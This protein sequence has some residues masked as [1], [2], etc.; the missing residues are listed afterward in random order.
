MAKMVQELINRVFPF[1]FLSVE[2]QGVL[3]AELEPLRFDDGTAIIRQ[4]DVADGGVYIIGAGS[5]RVEDPARGIVVGRIEAGHYFGEWEAL[6]DVRRVYSIVAEAG[7]TCYRFSFETFLHLIEQSRSFAQS[8][9]TILRDK[10]GIFQAFERFLAEIRRDVGQGF[11]NI[12]KLLPLYRALEPALHSGAKS[13]DT[14]DFPALAYAI[15]R[16]PANVSRT[17]AYLLTYELP[18]TF[19][20]PSLHFERVDTD[21]RRR[22]VWSVLPGKN[23]ILLRNGLSDLLDFTTCLC[24]YANEAKKL[25][26]RLQ[27]ADS[28]ERLHELFGSAPAAIEPALCDIGFSDGEAADLVRLWGAEAPRRLYEITCHREM[29]SIAVRHPLNNYNTRRA[30]QWTTHVSSTVREL[31]DLSPGQMHEDYPVHIVSSNTHSV[32]NVLSPWV[33]RRRAEVVAWAESVGHPLAAEEFALDDDRLYALLRDFSE[34]DPEH[35]SRR[36]KEDASAGIVTMAKTASTGIAVQLVDLSRLPAGVGD[37]ALEVTEHEGLL[38]NI[39][40][41]FGEQAQHILHHLLLLFGR[42]IRSV[43]FFG[44]AGALVGERGGV[45]VPDAF[46]EQLEDRV[47]EVDNSAQTDALSRVFEVNRGTMITVAG[48]LLQNRLMLTYY[49]R[50]WNCI[51]I[52]MEGAHYLR[53][54]LTARSQGL[55]RPDVPTSFLYYVSDLPMRSGRGLTRALTPMEGVPPL[56]AITRSVI[57]GV[58][59]ATRVS[60]REGDRR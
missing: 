57:S 18:E 21:A 42:R 8:L 9:A 7:C 49:R 22:A 59:D 27:S 51:G 14:I 4:G 56:Y 29:I 35:G 34:A 11:I 30:E 12:N 25:R 33:H 1:R 3:A 37:D 23:L 41:A 13:P 45:I 50:L 46:L 15:R 32:T 53:E 17:P 2:Q 5:V 58:L 47:V 31:L 44:K 43:S 10:Q 28:L 52:E 36:A 26:R 54:M 16:L 6:F 40:Y 20:N 60:A 48:T 38:V 39:D 55:V 19:R 24:L